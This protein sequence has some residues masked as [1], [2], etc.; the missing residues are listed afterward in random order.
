MSTTIARRT[1]PVWLAVLLLG[2]WVATA[3]AQPQPDAPNDRRTTIQTFDADG[4]PIKIQP[5]NSAE[6]RGKVAAPAA[7]PHAG[8]GHA[9]GE[10]HGAATK[11][12]GGEGAD[13]AAKEPKS[14]K[15]GAILFWIFALACVGGAGFVI[16]RRNLIAAVMGM[17][18]TF[19]AVAAVYAM[20]YAHFLAVIQVLVY[21]GAIMV[22]FVFVIMILNRP[23]D[24]PWGLVGLPGKA[25]AALAMAYLTFRLVGVLWTVQTVG[26]HEVTVLETK[27]LENGAVVTEPVTKM[28]SDAPGPDETIVPGSHVIRDVVV[29]SGDWGSTISVGR[30]LFTEY[31]FPF[32]AISILLLIA[33]VGAIAVARPKPE[34]DDGDEGGGKDSGAAAAEHHA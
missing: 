2:A 34:D 14:S 12:A 26:V 20:L 19:F 15:A 13:G 17:V 25:L 24:E 16:T 23:E 4:K 32:E 6:P 1:L 30:V 31:L 7:D 8:H 29:D 28:I 10:G 5:G 21:A 3:A 9:P 18:G 22:L 27:T 11:A 33:V